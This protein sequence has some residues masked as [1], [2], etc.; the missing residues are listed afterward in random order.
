MT[1]PMFPAGGKPLTLHGKTCEEIEAELARERVADQPPPVPND[2]PA[3]WDLVLADMKERDQVGRARYSTPLQAF[4]GR[5][6]LVDA[7]QEALDLV[8]YLRQAIEEQTSH[9]VPSTPGEVWLDQYGRAWTFVRYVDLQQCWDFH[10]CDN[11]KD[12]ATLYPA[13]VR[14]WRPAPPPPKAHLMRE[15]AVLR[16]RV[17][18][19][20]AENTRLVRDRRTVDRQAMVREFFCAAEQAIPSRLAI[21]ADDVVRFRVRLI[22]EEFFELLKATFHPD[23]HGSIDACERTILGFVGRSE[24]QVN[25]PE[26]C[27]ATV[28]LDYV[29]EGA[30]VAF[31]VDSRPLW[32]AVHTANLAKQ[33]GPVRPEDG[34]RL[35]PPGWT[36]PD[37]EGELRKQGW[38][39]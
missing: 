3:V 33:G 5:D 9:V 17:G 11:P 31:G 4:N 22:A 14:D 38:E 19:F 13:G 16:E 12:L 28:D 2:R 1:G 36:P 21:P 34:K 18:F 7:Y 37:I 25:L 15:V 6:P 29:V 32:T 24:I 26:W 39:G 35:K 10:A 23:W 27:D 30:R 20:M 8:V